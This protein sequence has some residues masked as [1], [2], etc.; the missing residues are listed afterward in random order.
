MK[1]VGRPLLRKET[2][3]HISVST[4]ERDHINVGLRIVGRLLLLKDI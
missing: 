1:G 4:L 3:K 2:L